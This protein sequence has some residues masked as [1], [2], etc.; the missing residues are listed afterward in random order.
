MRRNAGT[1]EHERTIRSHKTGASSNPDVWLNQGINDLSISPD[2]LYIATA[3]D[4]KCI[5]IHA[6]KAPTNATSR[7]P[8]LRRLEGHTAPVLC[9]AFSPKSD[10]L[11][12]GSFDESAILWDVRTGNILRV[13]PAHSEAVWTVAWDREAGMI[14]TGSADGSMRVS[15]R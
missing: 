14:L 6:L 5:N 4:D 10:C 1:G 3:S 13:L 7:I 15:L 2:G 12:S 8:S 9:T 11:V